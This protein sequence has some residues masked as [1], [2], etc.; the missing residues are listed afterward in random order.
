MFESCIFGENASGHFNE[1]LWLKGEAI[2]FL[3]LCLS[4]ELLKLFEAVNP[5]IPGVRNPC[6]AR[7]CELKTPDFLIYWLNYCKRIWIIVFSML[8]LFAGFLLVKKVT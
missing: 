6:S 3:Y 8:M 7:H 2:M 4:R 5:F 1:L